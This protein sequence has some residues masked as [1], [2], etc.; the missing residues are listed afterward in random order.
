[1]FERR[2][3]LFLLVVAV[4]AMVLIARAAQ[5]QIVNRDYWKLQ[6]VEAMK[7]TYLLDTTR[8]DILDRNGK[9][10]A[11]DKPCIDACVDYRA[12]TTPPDKM[13]VRERA[14]ERLK[15]RLGD[16]WSKLTRKQK[17]A[18]RDQE[19]AAVVGDIDNMWSKL[20]DL[21]GHSLDDIEEAREAIVN[22]VK[23]RRL[24]VWYKRSSKSPTIRVES[25]WKK[26]IADGGES[27]A[28]IDEFQVTVAEQLEPHVILRAVDSATQNELAKDI[29][30]YPGLVLRPGAHRTY[31]YRD[32][33]CHLIG[34]IGRVGAEDVKDNAKGNELRNYLPNDLIGKAGLESLCEPALRGS[35]GKMDRVAGEDAVLASQDPVRGGD[36]RTTIDIELQGQIQSAF[37]SA[38]IRD[39][40]GV[41][42]EDNAILHG[43]AVVLDV[44]TNQVLALVSY[45]TYDLNELDEIYPMLRDD[46]IN[47]PLRNRATMSQLEPGST[48]KPFCGLAGLSEGVVKINEGIECT[49]R[50]KLDGRFI[51]GGGRC[52]VSSMFGAQLKAIGMSD[53]HH[54]IPSKSPH[55]GHDGNA[56]GF[57]TYSDALERSCNIYFETVADRLGIDRLSSW[58]DRFGLGRPTGIG[59]GEMKGRLPRSFPS[60]F[61]AMRRSIGFFGG[62]GQGYMSAT[63]IQMANGAAMIARDGIWMRPVL[64][65]PDAHGRA[66]ALRPGA[67]QAV[68]AR[69]DLNLAP[70]ALRAAKLGMYNVVNALAGTGT[71]LVV[72]DKM[73]QALHIC[74]KTGTAQAS[75]FTVH[76]RDASGKIV[77]DEKNQPV[78][79]F[80]EPSTPTHRNLEAPWYRSADA[81]GKQLDH[82]WYIGFA[83][84]E[85]PKIAF[86][87]MVEYGGSGGRAAASVAR[88]AL[89][90]CI[91]RGYLRAPPSAAPAAQT[92]ASN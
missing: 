47:D 92:A 35:R 82:A 64:L 49:G 58:Y 3:K 39:S 66:P 55:K 12:L 11:V 19:V 78:R 59:I 33:A 45:P 68:P 20:A 51:P 9:I 53:A 41:V 18:L 81:E 75:R 32:I 14:V 8:G 44:Q 86:A 10:L 62:I 50:L 16:A 79:R 63:P 29:D 1:M 72:G 60:N 52:W 22:R 38:H 67:W 83:P 46:E 91:S 84:A 43:A 21:S 42:E 80:I 40:N 15:S 26:W 37:A 7:H 73:L 89:E 25:D 27:A 30:R 76:V 77:L 24:N 48:V 74:G 34:H 71:S 13:W 85:H 88:D 23:I 56:D 6:A 31:P 57:L 28:P 61:P 87:V 2:V 4:V 5:V 69:V 36:V 17:E 54:P 65:M 90:A 70:E